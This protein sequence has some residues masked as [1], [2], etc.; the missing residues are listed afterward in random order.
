VMTIP[1]MIYWV[2]RAGKKF[3]PNYKYAAIYLK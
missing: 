3:R 1:N 2:R